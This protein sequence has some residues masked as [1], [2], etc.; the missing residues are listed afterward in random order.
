MIKQYPKTYEDLF[1][2]DSENNPQTQKLDLNAVSID[3]MEFNEYVTTYKDFL[4]DFYLSL[5]NESVKFVWLRRKFC[6]RGER[7]V[8]Q[9]IGN[10]YALCLAFAKFTRRV[11]GRDVQ[12]ITKNDFFKSIEKKLDTFFPAF[13]ER[14]PFTD[15]ESYKFPFKNISI[16]F[17]PVVSQLDDWLDLLKIADEKKMS[18]A[19][20]VDY[21]IN[22]VYNEDKDRYVIRSN[23]HRPS[24]FHITDLKKYPKRKKK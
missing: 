5:F 24:L 14:N 2:S 21:V 10:S 23:V 3:G 20:F 22:Y 7:V 17:F 12:V 11:L 8:S 19:K 13:D 18:Y 16:D 1:S 4:N 15:P 6:Y 9:M